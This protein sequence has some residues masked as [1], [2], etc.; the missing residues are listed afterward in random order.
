[1]F[2]REIAVQNERKKE[3]KLSMEGDFYSE[4]NMDK[5]LGLSQLLA[6]SLCG[7]RGEF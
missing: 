2:L 6:S 4:E 5:K 1:M 3:V 7:S